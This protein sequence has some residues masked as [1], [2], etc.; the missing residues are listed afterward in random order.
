MPKKICLIHTETTGLHDLMDQKVYK[1]NLFGFARLV[2][3]SWLIAE[4]ITGSDF[5]I[6]K[7]ETFIIKPRCLVIPEECVKFHG[8]SHEI[9]MKKG[10]E[11]E[12]VLDK[13]RK[14]ITDVSIISSHGLEF[15]LKAV[16]AELVRYNKMVDF[17]KFLL[18]D[19]NSFDHKV[20]NTSLPNL[21]IKILN[22]NKS[23]I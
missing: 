4:R 5:N 3:F 9:A 21:S 20:T 13:F 8:I 14:D 23:V 1:K 17:N 7:K 16:Q 18:I 22:K 15:H 6:I 12:E 10:T 19:I 11:I 2:S